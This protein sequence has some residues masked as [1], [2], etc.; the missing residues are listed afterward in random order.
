MLPRPVHDPAKTFKVLDKL[1][2]GIRCG[3]VALDQ[4]TS[5][6]APATDGSIQT[7][8]GN[9]SFAFPVFVNNGQPFSCSIMFADELSCIEL[10]IAGAAGLELTVV[11]IHWVGPLSV[12]RLC[13]STLTT[14]L[15]LPL[16]GTRIH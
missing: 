1:V 11:G 10:D 8:K 15:L 6:A 3:P 4:F 2:L 9:Q 14:L 5:A 12:F 7:E 16:M 13:G